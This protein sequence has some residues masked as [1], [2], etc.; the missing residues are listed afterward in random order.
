VKRTLTGRKET[1]ID[2]LVIAGLWQLSSYYL[3]PI[4][5]PSL[6][7][8]GRELLATVASPANLAHIGATVA[9]IVAA[10]VISF[11]VGGVSGL[12][13]AF[14][15]RARRYLEP[16]LHMI[17]GVPA[18]SWVVFAVIWFARPEL[19]ILFVLVITTVPNFALHL[20]DAIRAIPRDL[21]ELMEAFRARRL[22]TV[23]LLVIPSIVPE[24]LTAWKVNVGNSTRV[25]VVAELVGA[26]LGVGYQLLS[27]QQVFNMAGAVAWTLVLVIALAA[28]QGVLTTIEGH[29]LRWRPPRQAPA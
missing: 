8:I 7:E 29:L 3:P 1:V 24:V 5:A 4:L 22:Q 15:E 13:M 18:L 6:L 11:V 20:Q 2:V 25:A 28:I 26:T 23:R 10:L 21:W 9:R 19:R 12:V 17:Q 27:A 14:S 16:L